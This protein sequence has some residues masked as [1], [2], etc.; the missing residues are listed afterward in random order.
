[1]DYALAADVMLINAEGSHGTSATAVRPG[2]PFRNWMTSGHATGC[3]PND[4][5]TTT[6]A[7]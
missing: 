6:A 5:R 2:L 1:M 4:P 7:T 3:S